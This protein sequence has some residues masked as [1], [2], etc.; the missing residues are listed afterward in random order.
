ME[1]ILSQICG[2]RQGWHNLGAPGIAFDSPHRYFTLPAHRRCGATWLDSDFCVVAGRQK[3]IRCSLEIP[4]HGLADGF[5]WGVWLAVDDRCFDDYRAHFD[6]DNYETRYSGKIGNL[7]PGY[8]NTLDVACIA[9]PQPDGERP[10]IEPASPDHPL[11]V[12][13]RDG[14][15]WDKA[16]AIAEMAMSGCAA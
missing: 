15:A 16:M 10:V 13:F 1:Q 11:A 3:F 7:L 4:V 9:V 8:P 2:W 5:L 6:D 12:D 14:I